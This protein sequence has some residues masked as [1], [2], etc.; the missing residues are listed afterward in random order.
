M[1]LYWPKLKVLNKTNLFLFLFAIFI[2]IIFSIMILNFFEPNIA[3]EFYDDIARN[4]INGNGYIIN[5]GESP[6]LWRAPVYPFFLAG[7]FCL[8]GSA[9][10]YAILFQILIDS[11]TCLVIFFIGKSVY[12]KK[13][14]LISAIAFILY[15]F[16]SYYT[17]HLLSESL[18][19][20]LLS[21]VILYLIRK[22]KTGRCWDFF[23]IGLLAGIAILCKPSL[24]YSPFFIL[25]GLFIYFKR[26]RAL[27][28]FSALAIGVFVV[29]LPWVIRN[30]Y[31]TDSF[32]LGTGG[33]YNL[34]LGNH[35]PT[36]GKDHD[37]LDGEKLQ[38]LKDS[39]SR[40][41][42][43]KGDQFT[44]ENDKKFF[45]EALRG[46][47]DNPY[48]TILLIVKKAFRFWF[49][50]YHPDHK[51]FTL[52]LVPI[53]GL[54]LSLSLV[55][56][57]FSIKEKTEIFYPLAIIIYFNLIHAAMVSTFRYSIPVMLYVILFA[58]YGA[59]KIRAWNWSA[60]RC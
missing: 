52:F 32:F 46:I 16:F 4:L 23:V 15:P 21:L 17:V 7:I 33:G 37:E 34:W 2:K 51:K 56:I 58:V 53:Q 41:T 48:Q 43:G 44:V 42:Q 54:I 14:G 5:E 40:V 3:E 11:T 59:H 38:L 19:T 36:D 22:R 6:N 9:N 27:L 49:Y 26:K 45:K 28:N 47:R 60:I 30:Y 8:F 12:N 35:I 10:L 13:I 18:F 57:Y 50:I 24:Q 55:G 29:I 25:F 39:I 20:L 31:V 1:I